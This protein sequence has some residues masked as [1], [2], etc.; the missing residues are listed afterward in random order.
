[1]TY[2]EMIAFLQ[3]TP[4]SDVCDAMRRLGLSGYTKG[5]YRLQTGLKKSM[6]GPALTVSYIPKQAG[7]KPP[8][9]QFAFARM[10]TDGKVLVID[11]KGTG[12]WLTG[13][14]VCRVAELAG[15][16][17]VVVDGCMRDTE[18]IASHELPVYCKGS[19]C[20]PYSEEMQLASVNEPID[21]DGCRVNPGDIVVGDADGICV[22]PA[23]RLAEVVY[24]AEEIK[25]IEI[26]LAAAVE[27]CAPLEELNRIA[28]RKPVLRK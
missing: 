27:A 24:Q 2:E 26:E 7:L 25:E 5:I 6:A 12:C 28:S 9:G 3:D 19:G 21:I 15:A 13:G 22:F 8:C 17:G 1:M 16:G 10:A 14:N 23:D 4:S 20:K 18:E 11:A